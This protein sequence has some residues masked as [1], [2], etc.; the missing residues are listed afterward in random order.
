VE[1]AHKTCDTINKTG[2]RRMRDAVHLEGARDGTAHGGCHRRIFLKES[3]LR[4]DEAQPAASASAATRCSETDLIAATNV[5]SDEEADPTWAC[6]TT[7]LFQATEPLPWWDVRQYIRDVTSGNHSAGHVLRLLA[8]GAFRALNI[9]VGIVPLR[10]TTV[11]RRRGGKPFPIT[12][13][14]IPADSPHR[15]GF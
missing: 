4:R 12:D 5:R 14:A 6:Q 2:G 8:F 7:A 15:S 10:R 13:G 1:V 3:W 9:G 11:S